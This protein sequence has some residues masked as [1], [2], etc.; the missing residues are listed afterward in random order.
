MLKRNVYTNPTRKERIIERYRFTKL[1]IINRYA[2]VSNS[3]GIYLTPKALVLL[4][5]LQ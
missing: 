5:T 4:S 2:R 1:Q 3:H